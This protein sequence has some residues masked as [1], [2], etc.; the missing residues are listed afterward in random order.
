MLNIQS[1]VRL[2]GNLVPIDEARGTV[3]DPHY[4]EGA[5]EMTVDDRPI[6]TKTMCDLVDQL[7]AYLLTGLEDIQTGGNYHSY[8]PDQPISM[9]LRKIPGGAIE[10]IVNDG[11]DRHGK[12]GHGDVA[13]QFLP[14]AR[15]FFGTM[16]KV[17]PDFVDRYRHELQRI[18]RLAEIFGEQ[19]QDFPAK[20]RRRG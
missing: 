12:I 2:K 7:W 14:S 1:Y 6:L 15:R 8:F 11:H 19:P 5:I 3:Q 16:Q 20:A 9:M 10:I 18:D 13:Q 4:V 17:N